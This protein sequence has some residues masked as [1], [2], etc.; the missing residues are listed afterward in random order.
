MKNITNQIPS[1]NVK[2]KVIV[3]GLFVFCINEEK[4]QAE[5]G[6][7]DFADDHE[8][9]VA[10]SKMTY[11]RGS[12]RIG[13]T[14]DLTSDPISTY[15]NNI[16]IGI[17][18][19]DSDILV[20]QNDMLGEAYFTID[21]N[22]TEIETEDENGEPTHYGQDFR[23]VIDL[24]GSRFYNQRLNTT[25]GMLERRIVVNNGIISTYDTGS[26]IVRN[27]FPK[28]AKQEPPV[29]SCYVSFQL[30]IDLVAA[31]SEEAIVIAYGDQKTSLRNEISLIPSADYYYEI[32]LDNNCKKAKPNAHFS[33]FQHYYN[34]FASVTPGD[35]F[36]FEKFDGSGTKAT[37]CDLVFLGQHQSLDELT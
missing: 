32:R 18:G 21:P 13:E 27:A 4:K 12:K 20:Y 24:E 14:I 23:W 26:R 31:S 8:F 25:P 34:V 2:A 7:Y 35:R 6:I 1:E 28:V 30:A 5:F 29:K 9:S 17:K 19:R 33:D 16:S 3:E 36:D 15:L 37:P 11:G 22:D 10:I